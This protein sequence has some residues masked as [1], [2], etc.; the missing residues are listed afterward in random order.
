MPLRTRST[1]K[2]EALA[3]A[4][5]YFAILTESRYLRAQLDGAAE[6]EFFQTGEDYV[7]SLFSTIRDHLDGHFAAATVLEAGC[8][9]GRLAIPFARRAASVTAADSSEAMLATLRH[10]VERFAIDNIEAV[11]LGE[12]LAG[13][14]L[15]NLVNCTLV[16]Q[17]LPPREGMELIG[18]LTRRVAPAGI[19]A[20][21]LP[22]RSAAGAALR[23]ARAARARIPLVNGLLNLARRKPFAFPFFETHTYGLNGVFGLLQASGF[24]DPH[25]V[26]TEE[27]DLSGVI[28][29]AQRRLDPSSAAGTHQAP[30]EEPAAEKGHIDVR[31]LMAGTTVEALNRKAEEYF[32]SLTDWEHHLAKPFSKADEAPAILINFGVLLQGLRIVPGQTLLDFGAGSGWLS[33]FFTQLGCQVISLDV[34]PTALRMAEELYGK[35]PLI[36]DRPAP[37]FLLYDGSAIDLPNNSVD[38]IVCFD[39]FHHSTDPARVLAEFGRILKPGGIAGF[40]EPGPHHSRTAQSQFEMRTYGVIE[41]DVDIHEIWGAAQRFG[42]ADLKLAAF[43]VPPFHVPLHQ[44]EDLLAGGATYGRWAASTRYFLGDVRNFFL[45]KG[46]SEE[47]DSRYAEALRCTIAARLE[48]PAAAGVPIAVHA[49]VTNSGKGVW[50]PSGDEPGAVAI[51]AHLYDAAGRLLRFDFHWEDLTTP[52]RRIEPGES[53]SLR[54]LLP[55]LDPGHYLVELDCVSSKVTWFSQVG[56]VPA[57]VE[58]DVEE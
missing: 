40:A 35:Q 27:G 16:L 57:K 51:G 4:E 38:R 45:T 26:F 8:G 32:A 25:V 31:E 17:R 15:F 6:S 3:A 19:L 41:N 34:S 52:P 39:A 33:R 18:A 5:P 46:G 1:E 44:Y 11:T 29:C 24:G 30:A 47:P 20:L 36:G 9:A 14:R 55:P 58:I 50:L 37:R 28:V 7:G 53:V 21:H 48:G 13:R 23:L 22:Y 2:W 12:L 42:F 10:N 54:V 49:V 43:N 56:S